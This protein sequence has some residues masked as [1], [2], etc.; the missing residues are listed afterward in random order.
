MKRAFGVRAGQLGFSRKP[1]R[2]W[3]C[4]LVQVTYLWFG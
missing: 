2:F 3:Q 1:S 4:E